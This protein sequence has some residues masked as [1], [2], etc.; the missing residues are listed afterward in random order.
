[1]TRWE[2]IKDDLRAILA[3]TLWGWGISLISRAKQIHPKAAAEMEVY[4]LQGFAAKLR[5]EMRDGDKS[6]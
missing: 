4:F 2:R 5:K 1:M 6:D 3:Y